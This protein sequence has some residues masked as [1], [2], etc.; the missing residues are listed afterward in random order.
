MVYA[1]G[2]SPHYAFSV[3][4]WLNFTERWIGGRGSVE[5]TP[6]SPGFK[7]MDFLLWGYSKSSVYEA[8]VKG[9]K[10]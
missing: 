10:R 5:W 8:G 1:G 7:V 6:R 4:H 3:R 2:A 9:K